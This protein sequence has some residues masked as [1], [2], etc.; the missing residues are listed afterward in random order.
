[1]LMKRRIAIRIIVGCMAVL[2]LFCGYAIWRGQHAFPSYADEDSIVQPSAEQEQPAQSEPSGDKASDAEPSTGAAPEAGASSGNAGTG[3]PAQ[4][5]GNAGTTAPTQPQ[6]SAGTAENAQPTEAPT[7]D[8]AQTAAQE[9]PTVKT[10][11]GIVSDYRARLSA[12]AETYFAKVEALAQDARN[13]YHALPKEE[14][15]QENKERIVFDRLG[16]LQSLEAS[17]DEEITAMLQS[18]TD[19]LTALGEDTE[20]VEELR[21]EYEVSKSELENRYMERFRAS[22]G[23][24]GSSQ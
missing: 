10:R 12:L 24:S 9:Q 8:G 21:S 5:Q 19:E 22:S 14:Q 3:Q 17:C 2:L 15:T 11:D 23:S 13:E 18:L 7:P 20:I 16:S 4:Q 1:M 6:G